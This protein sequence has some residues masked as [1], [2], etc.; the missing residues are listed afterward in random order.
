LRGGCGGGDANG[1]RSGSGSDGGRGSGGGVVGGGRRLW[2]VVVCVVVM[3]A[4]GKSV[5]FNFQQCLQCGGDG[6]G[7][8]VFVSDGG[9]SSGCTGGRCGGGK[10]LY[11][12]YFTSY[13]RACSCWVHIAT[14][15]SSSITG[16]ICYAQKKQTLSCKLIQF[17]N[18]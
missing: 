1:Y 16:S 15:S 12:Q 5:H 17:F 2:W 18:E 11:I 14:Q 4:G 6:G 8:G 9:G 13:T 3:W 10:S 7:F